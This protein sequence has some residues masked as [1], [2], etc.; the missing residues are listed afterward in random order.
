MARRA[1]AR[2]NDA[3]STLQLSGPQF[4]ALGLGLPWQLVGEAGIIR[5][6]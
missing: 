6:I 5:V 1:S 2:H 3:V 4:D